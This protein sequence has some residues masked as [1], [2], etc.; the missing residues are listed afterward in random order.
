MI[1]QVYWQN[2]NKHPESR[3]CKF[4]PASVKPRLIPPLLYNF[5][6]HLLLLSFCSLFVTL[7]SAY[8][9][10]DFLIQIKYAFLDSPFYYMLSQS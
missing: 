1:L 10:S 2:K 9:T 3:T 5:L 8:S 4:K 6:R 7:H